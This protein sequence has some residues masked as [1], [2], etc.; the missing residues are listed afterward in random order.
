V[1][2]SYDLGDIPIN[3][4]ARDDVRGDLYA[5]S[6]FAV[7]RLRAGGTSWGLAAPG[8]PN[9][10]VSGLVIRS[11]ERKLYAATHGLSAWLLNLP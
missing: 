11:A 1:D 10:E 2:V 8:M 9:G 3:D 4:V 6:D 5:A 7:Y